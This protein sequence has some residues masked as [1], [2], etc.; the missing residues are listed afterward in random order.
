MA[1]KNENGLLFW[2][3]VRRESSF[4]IVAVDPEVGRRKGGW[5]VRVARKVAVILR[6]DSGLAMTAQLLCFYLSRY[7]ERVYRLP[8]FMEGKKTSPG[9]REWFT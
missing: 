6:L 2:N 7:V 1:E 8:N 3:S 5:R 4:D 9:S